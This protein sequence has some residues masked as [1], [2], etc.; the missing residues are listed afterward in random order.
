MVIV[1]QTPAAICKA[2]LE[3]E[4]I[5]DLA[6]AFVKKLRAESTLEILDPSLKALDQIMQDAATNAPAADSNP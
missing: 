3:G 2:E 6:P 1:V 4:Q 5:R